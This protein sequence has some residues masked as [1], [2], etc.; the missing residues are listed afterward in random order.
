MHT[1]H[2]WC[3]VQVRE[4]L[5]SKVSK[6]RVGAELEGM[7]NGEASGMYFFLIRLIRE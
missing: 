3:V 2:M 7:F 4:A 6:E 1:L 5:G